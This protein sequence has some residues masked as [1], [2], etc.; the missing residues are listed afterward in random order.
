MSEKLTVV[1]TEVA[2]YNYDACGKA[3]V[4]NLLKILQQP[5]YYTL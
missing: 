2:S 5:W 4:S 3:V 1:G